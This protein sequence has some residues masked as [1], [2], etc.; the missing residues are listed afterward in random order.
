M[1]THRTLLLRKFLQAEYKQVV[2]ICAIFTLKLIFPL[3]MTLCSEWK[4]RKRNRISYLFHRLGCQGIFFVKC[5]CGLP[6]G[7]GPDC[8]TGILL[9]FNTFAEKVSENEQ[10]SHWVFNR[11]FDFNWIFVIFAQIIQDFSTLPGFALVP[12]SIPS[13]A[14]VTF[15]SEALTRTKILVNVLAHFFWTFFQRF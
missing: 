5:L 12:R 6:V 7:T 15:S 3:K 9:L 8:I 4:I 10:F 14:N 13:L 2:K 1:V 11:I